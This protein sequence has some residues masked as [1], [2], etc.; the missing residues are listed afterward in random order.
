LKEEE[1]SVREPIARNTEKA[2]SFEKTL[3]T[4]FKK[5]RINY[6]SRKGGNEET[7]C[8]IRFYIRD[9][10]PGFSPGVMHKKELPGRRSAFGQVIS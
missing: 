6:G 1:M 2:V 3:K 8:R 5:K 4:Y 10:Q 9:S 7:K